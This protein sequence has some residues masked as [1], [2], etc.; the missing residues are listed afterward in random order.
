LIAT[1]ES[2]KVLVTGASGFVGSALCSYLL[3]HGHNVIGTVRKLPVSPVLGVDYRIIGDLGTSTAWSDDVFSGVEIIIHCAA[4][5]HVMNEYVP[6]PL[7]E[8]RQINTQGTETLARLAANAGV[9]RLIFLSSVKVNGE[10]SSLSSPIDEMSPTIPKDY[11]GI[12]KLEA[13]KSLFN[14]ADETG[15]ETVIFRLPLVYGPGVKGN[16]LRLLKMVDRGIPLPFSLV[17]NLRSLI[18]LNNLTDVVEACLTDPR[19]VGKT[20]MVSD[21]EDISTIQ[22]ITKMARALERP[23]RLWP[24]PLRLIE[25]AGML[26]GRSDETSRLLGSLRINSK[27][28]Y[29]DLGWIP[30]YTLTQGLSQISA[31][32][33]RKN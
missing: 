13:E 20:Y 6:D 7:K 11:Y 15:L 22:L 27:K 33:H 9:R 17:N 18:N 30:P 2:H 24:C 8:F 5:V 1:L 16:F 28:I 25:L 31:W 26:S 21:S 12:S 14:I 19:A 3:K 32:H 10:N 4:R 23:V 29:S